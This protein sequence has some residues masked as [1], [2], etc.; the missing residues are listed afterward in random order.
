M[1]TARREEL[2]PSFLLS[3]RVGGCA[4]AGLRRKCLVHQ[5][6]DDV[7]DGSSGLVRDFRDESSVV[8]MECVEVAIPFP[9]DSTVGVVSPKYAA[10]SA[11]SQARGRHGRSESARA[12][13]LPQSDALLVNCADKQGVFFD[14]L[15]SR[16][17]VKDAGPD[18]LCELDVVSF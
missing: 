15:P 8:G 10:S 13:V 14:S 2:L 9:K 5:V 16:R 12:L 7:V 17:P 18:F 6:S 3:V 4:V 1:L 11:L